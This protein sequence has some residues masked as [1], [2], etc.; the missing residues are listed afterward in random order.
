MKN[1][2]NFCQLSLFCHFRACQQKLFQCVSVSLAIHSCRSCRRDGPVL[3]QLQLC[4]CG[5]QR[6][7]QL[8]CWR[9]AG[10]GGRQEVHQALCILCIHSSILAIFLHS[11]HFSTFSLTLTLSLSSH[12]RPNPR[13]NLVYGIAPCKYSSFELSRMSCSPAT[14]CKPSLILRM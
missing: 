7:R 8:L 11:F 13:W 2:E 3:L 4:R 12:H 5:W 14:M 6:P 10:G 9:Q 1:N